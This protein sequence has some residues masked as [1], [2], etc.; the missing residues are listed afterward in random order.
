VLSAKALGYTE[1]DPRDDLSGMDVARKIVCLAREMGFETKLDDVQVQTLIPNDLIDCDV[2]T[3]L[4]KLPHYD[5]EMKT[6]LSGKAGGRLCYVGS[7]NETGDVH[8]SVDVY[9]GDH[10]FAGP[11][12]SDNVMVF[13]TQR[14]HEQPLIIQGPGAGAQ[15]TAAGVFGDL[16]RLVSFLAL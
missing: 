14:Y 12:G 3:F 2:A 7:I 8:V 10:P 11:K 13:K 9:E 1:P 5:D 15:V 4:K 6:V 16:L